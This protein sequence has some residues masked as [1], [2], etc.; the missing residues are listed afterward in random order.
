MYSE[1]R[2][3]DCRVLELL[4]NIVAAKFHH[5]A[6]SEL[7]DTIGYD[8]WDVFDLEVKSITARE[9]WFNEASPISAPL[10]RQYWSRE[11]RNILARVGATQY[12][13]ALIGNDGAKFEEAISIFSAFYGVDCAD[14][15]I[16]SCF[17]H[18]DRNI[19][20]LYFILDRIPI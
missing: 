10:S 14:V 16:I 19:Y 8:I 9:L 2:R 17:R 15:R 7:V 11:V 6:I 12:I 20:S 18:L 5:V 13:E 3:L 1:R 4:D